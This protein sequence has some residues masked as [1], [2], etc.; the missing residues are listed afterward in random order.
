MAYGLL[1]LLHS[2]AVVV[3]PEHNH[4]IG[5]IVLS[6][7]RVVT[8]LQSITPAVVTSNTIVLIVNSIEVE[9]ISGRGG[10]YILS[11]GEHLGL[12]PKKICVLLSMIEM[13]C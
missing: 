6:V 11:D 4:L 1:L 3:P 10:V 5:C 13:I 12:I 7:C 8:D 9:D 2:V